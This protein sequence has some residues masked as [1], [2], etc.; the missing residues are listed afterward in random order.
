[1]TERAAELEARG[2]PASLAPGPGSGNPGRRWQSGGPLPGDP[3]PVLDLAGQKVEQ[4]LGLDRSGLASY[5][6]AIRHL[7]AQS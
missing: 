6:V 1:M 5:P 7:P 3:A 2:G 4:G